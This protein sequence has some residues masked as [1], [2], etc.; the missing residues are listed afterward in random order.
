V[1]HGETM[2]E[3][4]WQDL[5]FAGRTLGKSP[6]F[7]AVAVLTLALGIGGA[8]AIFSVA[9]AVVL[10]PLPF[11]DPDRIV[12]LWQRDFRRDQPFVEISYPAFRA[13]REQSRSFEEL[14]AMP[15]VDIGW[16]LTGRG[17]PERV[18]GR[19]VTAGFFDVLGVRPALGRPLLPDDDRPGAPP[20][21]V[22]SDALWRVRFGADPGIIGES[23]TL[24]GAP[25][26]VVGVMPPDFA[27]P[28]RAQLWTPLGSSVGGLLEN[29]G[30]WWMIA[31][32]R[33]R[34]GVVMAEARTELDSIWARFHREYFDPEGHGVALT[35]IGETM[36]GSTRPALL[37]LLGAVGLVLFIACANVAGLLIVRTVDRGAEIAIRQ[38]M[39]ATRVR[40]GQILLTET[41]LLVA[42]GGAVGLGV[43]LWGTPLLVA[44]APP[45]VPRV[46]DAAVNPRAFGFAVLVSGLS[47]LMCGLAPL[48]LLRRAS[49]EETFRDR[50]RTLASGRSRLRA[51]LV[52]AEVALA[53]V[54]LVGAGLLVRTL[55][56]LRQVP[57]G[58]EP[59]Q[60]LALEIAAP[61]HRYPEVRQWR[62]FYA[63]LVQRVQ[64]LPGVAAAGSVTLRPLWGTVGMDWSFTVEG[65]SE[66]EAARNPLLN[67]QAV[68]P[69]YFETMGIP[70]RRG[71]VFTDADDERQPGVV[72]VSETLARRH[73]P[74]QD[75][76]GK[77]LKI[78]LPET[79]YHDEWLSV[80]GVVGDARYRELQAARLDLYMSYR[81]AD[82]RPRH[83]VVRAH[84][85][86]AALAGSIREIVRA[87]DPEILVTDVITM[88]D[89]VAAALGGPRFAARVSGA[90]A[91]IAVLLAA[92]GLYGLLAYAVTRRTK[93]IGV[94][95]A[96]GAQR[97]DVRRLV[98]GEGLRLTTAGIA[99][100]LAASTAAG[101]LIEALLFGVSGFD[102]LSYAAG[103]MVLALIATIA[104]LIPAH[105]ATCVDPAAAL[106]AE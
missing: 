69:A 76:V 4:I 86:P 50:G 52:V 99:I 63:E 9:D 17:E 55:V 104:C 38:A 10:R 22:L 71:R 60:V 91:L 82:H 102:A 3:S 96:L 61:S 28:L 1:N 68:S 90:F 70:L 80:V 51:G 59:R 88:S 16:V 75:A 106:R 78:P 83:L 35:P 74:G 93:E 33:L 56:N 37:A 11:A 46:Q 25:Y 49:L 43:A 18:E 62:S 58:F 79:P 101:H 64:A 29:A 77:R 30:V 2:L 24:D 87:M 48:L 5:R 27:Y 97:G 21:V 105:R 94:R 95:M 100:G 6:G 81:Q 8:T 31:V 66:E 42:F 45:D 47:A 34:P 98:L 84:A 73:W 53:V 44:L 15:S 40:L 67:L 26:T 72:V 103:P 41:A 19:W 65:Q 32:G 89:A 14:A 36:L 7:T 13:W 85:A 57:L 20:V 92:L 12:V 39:G 54:L 23:L